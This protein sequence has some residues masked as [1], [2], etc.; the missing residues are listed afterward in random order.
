MLVVTNLLVV[1]LS[2]VAFH[3]IGLDNAGAWAVAAGLLH[4]VPYLGPAVT[5]GA[6]AM[7]AFMQFDSRCRWRCWRA[8]PSLAIATLVGTFVTTWMTGTDRAA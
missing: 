6:T 2:W 7:A 3:F 1:L 4:V 8:A 5:A